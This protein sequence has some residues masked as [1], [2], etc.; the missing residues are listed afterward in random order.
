MREPEVCWE[1]S[2]PVIECF[3]VMPVWPHVDEDGLTSSIG[4][5]W[6]CRIDQC[7][8]PSCGCGK[9]DQLGLSGVVCVEWIG[10]V[11]PHVDEGGPMSG[12]VWCRDVGQDRCGL[13]SCG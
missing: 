1:L 5:C 3:R 6:L 4:R 11:C 8:L 9:A 10:V 2:C 12:V 13:P 7:R